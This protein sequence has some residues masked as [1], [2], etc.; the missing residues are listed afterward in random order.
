MI[1]INDYGL[2][3]GR[4][5]LGS[6]G[7][8]DNQDCIQATESSFAANFTDI[9]L[10]IKS[11]ASPNVVILTSDVYNPSISAKTASG[12]S[13]VLLPLIT[14]IDNS[15]HAISAANGLGV[16]GVYSAFNG[17]TGLEDPIAKGY[18]APDGVHPSTLGYQVIATQF[19]NLDS[20]LLSA[21]SDGDGFSNGLEIH[22][23]TDLLSSCPQNSSDPAF[24]PDVNNDGRVNLI[25]LMTVLRAYGKD[26]TS[27]GWAS[28][29]KRFDF[30]LDGKIA[31]FDVFTELRNLGRSGC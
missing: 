11:L 30:R 3:A 25:D 6:C 9:I 31:W 16:V 8:A 10:Q 15:I 21:D 4:Y 1:G 24:P 18:V 17:A 5:L 22:L 14:Q 23:G 28:T 20:I 2:A 29:Y 19:G 27:P 12:S 26:S 13:A 7:G